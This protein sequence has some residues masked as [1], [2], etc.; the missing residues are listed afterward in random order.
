MMNTR[1]DELKSVSDVTRGAV[2]TQ[3]QGTPTPTTASTE[4]PLSTS[5]TVNSTSTTANYKV[6]FESPINSP[7]A[8]DEDGTINTT[9]P[10]TQGSPSKWDVIEEVAQLLSAKTT[11]SV[12]VPAS[13][14]ES[15]AY[16]SVDDNEQIFKRNELDDDDEDDE[17]GKTLKSS[18]LSS[19]FN[20]QLHQYNSKH[21]QIYTS[22]NTS[23]AMGVADSLTGKRQSKKPHRYSPNNTEKQNSLTKEEKAAREPSGD[24]EESDP[25][26]S[27]YD[28]SSEDSESESSVDEQ[29]EIPTGTP[30][31][32]K[33]R[34]AA[35]KKRKNSGK[36]KSSGKVSSKKKS[37]G[38][39]KKIKGE[40]ID[41]SSDS[42]IG[43]VYSYIQNNKSMA[44]CYSYIISNIGKKNT[45]DMLDSLLGSHEEIFCSMA[46]V[47]TRA[48]FHN[49]SEDIKRAANSIKA[50]K[51]GIGKREDKWK[52]YVESKAIENTDSHNELP[53]NKVNSQFKAAR[54]LRFHKALLGQTKRNSGAPQWE[55]VED[56]NDFSCL[57]SGKTPFLPKVTAKERIDTT[58]NSEDK[59][60]IAG[61]PSRYS[62]GKHLCK[63]YNN[64][65]HVTSND[66]LKREGIDFVYLFGIKE[67]WQ[68]KMVDPAHPV[69]KK[70]KIL[71][72]DDL[73]CEIG[74]LLYLD[75]RDT[76]LWG[77][78]VYFV[79]A[80]KFVNGM[81]QD[82]VGYV[83]SL[84]LDLEMIT[85]SFVQ[86]VDGD[87]DDVVGIEEGDI[88]RV[89]FIE[90]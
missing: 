2:V 72:D 21:N 16:D 56:E 14:Q 36:N 20:A 75:G 17:V 76:R 23:N 6:A 68:K 46:N 35:G 41:S 42:F 71:K 84:H 33:R 39:G 52:E 64:H 67:V 79:G 47:C 22:G 88:L 80:Y 43:G 27:S 28:E 59:R 90:L 51:L 89:K 87:R 66:I 58:L 40:Y 9:V 86:V 74:D 73:N 45:N 34:A 31:K 38:K 82:K 11:S 77:K 18:S 65:N 57:F 5:S 12:K 53:Y 3:T 19:S 78:C 85:N 24:P 50:K 49:F 30:P 37:T 54:G 32:K 61:F 63:K 69:P 70:K 4:A 48:Q 60:E 81:K 62:D 13:K 7:T 25:S 29:E 15:N 1:S 55:C 83:K 10:N 44:E 8:D 26:S